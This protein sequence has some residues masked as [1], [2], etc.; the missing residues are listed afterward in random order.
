MH[1]EKDVSKGWEYIRSA[2]N[3][4]D[5]RSQVRRGYEMRSNS[6]RNYT[7][8]TNQAI[9]SSQYQKDQLI[10]A[11]HY[12]LGLCYEKQI[13]TYKNIKKAFDHY[14]L[15]ADL[16]HEEAQ[17][18]IRDTRLNP[19]FLGSAINDIGDDGLTALER[20]V[21]TKPYN[22]REAKDLVKYGASIFRGNDDEKNASPEKQSKEDLENNPLIKFVKN[23]NVQ[24]VRDII[25]SEIQSIRNG[26]RDSSYL[27]ALFSYMSTK[28]IRGIG[29]LLEEKDINDI[30]CFFS[31]HVS[32][33]IEREFH[34]RE[35]FDGIRMKT[36]RIFRR[37]A[38][39][40]EGL[41]SEKSDLK[42][43]E[44]DRMKQEE[45]NQY[46]F[47]QTVYQGSSA[48][49]A[50]LDNID[51]IDEKD[52][53]ALQNQAERRV[54]QIIEETA[55]APYPVFPAAQEIGVH[56]PVAQV[57]VMMGDSQEVPIMQVE[58]ILREED[59][60][61][62]SNVSPEQPQETPIVTLQSDLDRLEGL[63]PPSE[64]NIRPNSENTGQVSQRKSA[65]E[66]T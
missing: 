48:P 38:T 53:I 31:Q 29:S 10:H 61:Q 27:S 66:M 18:R 35:M 52:V 62:S 63:T 1:V 16:G 44:K 37:R 33:N 65:L 21:L 6:F 5:V 14:K 50:N 59:L 40:N 45:E 46:A 49:P 23:G 19:T 34:S 25:R 4:G 26:S 2:A 32:G 24:T 58:H 28:T 11:A 43:E 54:E 64:V 9:G 8:A 47:S 57:V 51:E 36:P 41:I 55:S 7:L 42:Q 22:A 39:A 15:A 56:L 60:E 3:K 13:G 17:E 30:K 12:R 20:T